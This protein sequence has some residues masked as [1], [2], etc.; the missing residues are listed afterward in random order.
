MTLVE[1]FILLSLNAWV[2]LAVSTLSALLV[3]RK[4]SQFGRQLL[5]LVL[6]ASSLMV[7]L[8]VKAF[9]N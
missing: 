2:V 9:F 8:G 6:I 7:V 4:F 3:K 5:L 1:W